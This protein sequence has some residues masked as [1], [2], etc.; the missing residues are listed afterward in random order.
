MANRDLLHRVLVNFIDNALNHNPGFDRLQFGIEKQK[1][2]IVR[3]S[4]VEVPEGK[5][6]SG[7]ERIDWS[8]ARPAAPRS[9]GGL[10]LKL[11]N[12]FASAMNCQIGL[13]RHQSGIQTHYID[14]P[15]SRQMSLL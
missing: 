8:Q 15:A 13:I 12:Q 2:D 11:A 5:I 4:V 3:I 1:R 7:S 9:G 14:I 10:G 6:R